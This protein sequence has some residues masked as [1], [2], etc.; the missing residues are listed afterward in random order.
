MQSELQVKLFLTSLGFG[1]FSFKMRK[2]D[3]DIPE[4]CFSSMFYGSAGSA[5]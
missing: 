4:A 5:D 2:L 1:F 3:Q